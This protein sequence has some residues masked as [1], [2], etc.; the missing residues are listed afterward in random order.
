M[1]KRNNVC[2]CVCVCVCV[3]V[4][5]CVCVCVCARALAVRLKPSPKYW[6]PFSFVLIPFLACLWLEEEGGGRAVA[7]QIYLA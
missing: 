4:R 6:G 3:R 5:V 7:V 1:Q 2:V